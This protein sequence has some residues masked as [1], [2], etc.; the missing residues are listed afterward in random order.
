MAEI[1]GLVLGG[2]TLTSLVESC[3]SLF[4]IFDAYTGAA[5]EHQL[6]A[7]QLRLLGLRLHVWKEAFE[8]SGE[9]HG[10]PDQGALAKDALTTIQRL[11]KSATDIDQRHNP[12]LKNAA[13]SKR[14]ETGMA[15]FRTK[16]TR[17]GEESAVSDKMAWVLRAKPKLQRITSNIT[18][19][20]DQLEALAEQFVR[21]YHA[22]AWK[23]KAAEVESFMADAKQDQD[24]RAVAAEFFP[25]HR[26][27][28]ENRNISEH[29]ENRAGKNARVLQ[30]DH[31]ALGFVG[32]VPAT[33]Q[34][35]W[36]N[37][38]TDNARVQYGNSYGGKSIFD[39]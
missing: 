13:S 19:L 17:G 34:V 27:Y 33:R 9:G 5:K 2:I 28:Q 39:D 10:T 38:A 32:D 6:A 26:P 30:G 3:I 18:S 14:T 15:R 23:V 21:S 31:V 35:F 8:K 1:A 12:T 29:V 36:R 37:E 25:S 24:F 11:L 7:L 16:L 20:I 22:N 4:G